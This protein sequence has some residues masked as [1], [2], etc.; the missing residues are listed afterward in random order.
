MNK[1]LLF[2]VLLILILGPLNTT[3]ATSV[4]LGG[5]LT[6]AFTVNS[7]TSITAK[8]SSGASGNVVIST[9]GGVATTVGFIFVPAPTIT[10]FTPTSATLGATMTIAGSNFSGVTAV[11]IGG[12]AAQS[13]TVVSP[14]TILAVVGATSSGGISV[15]TSGGTS[16]LAGFTY[17]IPV[18]TITG[19]TPV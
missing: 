10:S 3:G 5:F 7:P 12:L 6:S 9:L 13:Y 2:N 8:V 16:T 17:I 18:P 19:F 1:F 14:T 4:G 11:K 15:T